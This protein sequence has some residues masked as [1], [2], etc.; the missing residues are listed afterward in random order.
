VIDHILDVGVSDYCDYYFCCSECTTSLYN[1][2]YY[3]DDVKHSTY[4]KGKDWVKSEPNMG[5]IF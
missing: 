4:S 2:S 1:H 3:Y 5:G